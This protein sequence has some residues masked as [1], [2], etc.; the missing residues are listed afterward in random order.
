MSMLNC[1]SISIPSATIADACCSNKYGAKCF[2]D[3]LNAIDLEELSEG[4]IKAF[5]AALKL[6]GKSVLNKLNLP[7]SSN[8]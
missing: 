5:Q 2:A 7:K 4:W 8:I 1:T 3:I 6:N